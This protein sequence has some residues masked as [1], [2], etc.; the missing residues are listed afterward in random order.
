MTMQPLPWQAHTA[1]NYDQL[2]KVE[3]DQIKT[4]I[5]NDQNYRLS[6]LN[7]PRVLHGQLFARFVPASHPEYAGTYRG[8]PGTSLEFRRAGANQLLVQGQNFS[9]IDPSQVDARMS[10][11]LS[12]VQSQIQAATG[13]PYYAKLLLLSHL[14]CW[15][16]AIHPFLDG[17]G[18]VQRSLFAALA[19]EIGIPVSNRFAIHPRTYDSLLAFPLEM[20]TRSNGGQTYLAMVAEYVSNWLD[21]PFDAPGTGIP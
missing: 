21:G 7:D 13:A 9:F 20:F 5:E 8:T 18:H 1:T 11:L 2:M 14:F 4:N 10:N 12:N 15:F 16:G 3:C 17:N 6:I 19:I